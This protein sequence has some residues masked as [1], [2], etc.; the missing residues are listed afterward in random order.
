M[1][2]PYLFEIVTGIL[3]TGLGLWVGY[4]FIF[5]G[6]IETP[7]YT[8]I[9]QY[10]ELEIREYPPAL[11]A[12]VQIPDDPDAQNSGFR[13]L[14]RYIFGENI[15]MTAPVITESN[16]KTT[17]DMTAPVITSKEKR[18]MAFVLPKKYTLE[19][20]PKPKDPRIKI[21]T[22][23]YKRIAALPFKGSTN[24]AMIERKTI[25]I[26]QLLAENNIPSTNTFQLAQYNSPFV[27]P[28][29]DKMNCG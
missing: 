9:E 20:L 13:I 16:E 24:S 2:V 1:K 4:G 3:L 11:I 10:S 29:L 27:F 15:P 21:K 8:L 7:N 17:I 14:A 18:T 28:Y 19:T 23:A 12:E 22:M 5:E 25:R 26:R 6:D